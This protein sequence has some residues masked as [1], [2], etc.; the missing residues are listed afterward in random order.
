[1]NFGASATTYLPSDASQHADAWG[2]CHVAS[3][4][5][6]MQRAS[7]AFGS[8]G[9]SYG[10]HGPPNSRRAPTKILVEKKKLSNFMKLTKT[11]TENRKRTTT[12]TRISGQGNRILSEP[13]GHDL[14]ACLVTISSGLTS[15]RDAS[16][17][18]LRRS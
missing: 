15:C 9:V 10:A 4:G 2:S 17:H 3:F 18:A 11:E 5:A 1:M 13:R 14:D 6:F 16:S 8:P 7:N 12:R